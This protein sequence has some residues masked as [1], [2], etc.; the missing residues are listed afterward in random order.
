MAMR[1]LKDVNFSYLTFYNPNCLPVMETLIEQLKTE[2]NVSEN[3]AIMIMKTISEFIETQHPILKD[4]AKD[5]F[6]KELEKIK[7]E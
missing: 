3:E 4:V 7:N 1:N 6:D 5:I 2:L